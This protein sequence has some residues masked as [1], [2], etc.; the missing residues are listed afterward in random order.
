M[1]AS[2]HGSRPVDRDHDVADRL[3]RRFLAAGFEGGNDASGV[4]LRTKGFRIF[5]KGRQR[6]REP[7]AARLG[8]GAARRRRWAGQRGR[9]ASGPWRDALANE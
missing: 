3:W 9:S 8:A 5:P 7:D 4:V 2:A 1:V 6:H